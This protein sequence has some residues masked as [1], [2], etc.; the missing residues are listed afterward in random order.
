MT[1]GSSSAFERLDSRIQ[2]WIWQS[3]WTELKDVQERAIH[4]ILDGSDDVILAAATASGK[5][6]AAFLPILTRVVQAEK[7]TAVLYVSPLKALINDQWG[8]LTG[9]A[10]SLDVAVIPWHGDISAS[11]KQRFAR[12][13]TGCL[14]I[15]PESLEGILMREGRA[16]ERLFGGLAY[17][18]VDELHAFI[19]TERGKQLQSLMQRVEVALKRRVPRVGLSATLG[20]MRLAA[21]FL[22]PGGG[23]AVNVIESADGGQELR[24]LL[25]GFISKRVDADLVREGAA[26]V[27]SEVAAHLYA[28]LRGTN[29]LIFPNSRR[30]VELIADKLRLLC[31]ANQVPNEFWPHHGSLS[32][33]IRSETELALKQKERPASAIATT[34]LE[35]GIDIGSVKSVAQVGPAPS[36]ASLRQRLGRS[37]RRRG[38]PAILRLYAIEDELHSTSTVS[39]QLHE[40]LVQSIAQVQLLVQ[41]WFEPPRL[42]ALNL[43]TLVQQVLSLVAQYGGVTVGQVWNVLCASGVFDGLSQREFGWLLRELGRRDILIQDSSGALLHGVV[44]ERIVNHYTFLAAF[45]TDDEYLVTAAG[46]TL[47]A[48]PL[49]RPVSAGSYLV[50]AGRRWRVVVVHCEERVLELEPAKS[51][52]VPLFDGG[53]GKTHD[54]VRQRMREVLASAEPIAFVDATGAQLV[55]EARA[56]YRRLGL[57]T[58]SVIGVGA[59]TRVFTWRGDWT[60]DALALMLT[61]RGLPAENEGMCIRVRVEHSDR[62]LDTL[63]DIAAGAVPTGEELARVV[64]NKTRGKWDRFLPDDL[65]NKNFASQELD[66]QGAVAVAAFIADAND[67]K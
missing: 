8:R 18:V 60:N 54:R 17:L 33:E 24:V 22:R 53:A 65:L 15:T 44:G 39:D 2:R 49:S 59:D 56:S 66:V 35:L 63:D 19:D 37:G 42:Q 43:S 36:V 26:P 3:G 45:V 13:P 67:A 27:W 55:A 38:E 30:T 21:E 11:M 52:N 61:A 10:E 20:D 48:L 46:K 29:N 64:E 51:G 23:G 16:L 6:E 57:E 62:L 58:S 1:S 31:E 40:G 5:T 41:G 32:K 28:S 47:G 7:P 12:K 14:L 34:T 4:A 9:L 50:F 25:K